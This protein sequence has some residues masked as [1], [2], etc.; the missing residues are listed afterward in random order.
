MLVS[1]LD[2]VKLCGKLNLL[3]YEGCCK[4]VIFKGVL[5]VVGVNVYFFFRF[6]LYVVFGVSW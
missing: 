6:V 4:L 1:Y 3:K 5:L 2:E